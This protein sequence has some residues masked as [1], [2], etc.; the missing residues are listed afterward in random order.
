MK[1]LGLFTLFI[2]YFIL[3]C[4][5]VNKRIYWLVSLIWTIPIFGL[6]F[7]FENVSEINGLIIL[8]CF[9]MIFISSKS[10]WGI[11]IWNTK[12]RKLNY[13]VFI[14][15][16]FIVFVLTYYT[17]NE[18]MNIGY[19]PNIPYISSISSKSLKNIINILI[20]GNISI[21]FTF[22]FY[23]F[24][25]KTIGKSEDLI[26]ICCRSY[27]I[28]LFYGT[29]FS[30]YYIE[31]INNGRQ[32]RFELTKRQYIIIRN[33]RILELKLKKGI[34]G[35]VYIFTNPCPNFENRAYR[36]DRKIARCSLLFFLLTIFIGIYIFII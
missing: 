25:D 24:I 31:G 17:F 5:I 3:D 13:Y 36:R 35:G 19:I 21:F 29:I 32:Y 11:L 28:N 30:R 33:E 10:I 20:W 34:L 2:V 16:Y 22:P 4:F 6:V 18:S 14:F 8:I 7:N 15:I 26:I 1:Y 23:N 27:G 9:F 12:D